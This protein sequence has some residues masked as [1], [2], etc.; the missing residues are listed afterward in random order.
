MI[1]ELI[2]GLKK[3]KVLSKM[4]I[5]WGYNNIRIKEGDKW[6]AAFHTTRGLY[7][8]TVMFFGLC[9]SPATFQA[10]MNKIFVELIREGLVKIYMNNI[11]VAIETMEDR[12]CHGYQ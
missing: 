8:L 3:S 11:L 4:D 9:N 5:W 7:E 2:N 10:F 6:K 1:G 12:V